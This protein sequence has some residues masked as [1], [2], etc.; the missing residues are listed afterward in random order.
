M[1]KMMLLKMIPASL[2]VEQEKF[3]DSY[4][5]QLSLNSNSTQLMTSYPKLGSYTI[6]REHKYALSEYRL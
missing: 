3:F 2:A 5:S 4:Q 6:W 1:N